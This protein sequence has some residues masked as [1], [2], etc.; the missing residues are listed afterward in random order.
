MSASCHFDFSELQTMARTL[1]G[2]GLFKADNPDQTLALMLLAQAEGRHPA[3]VVRDYNII[4]GRPAKK[5]EA[6]LRDFLAAGGRVEWR[7]LTDQ[8]CSA[9][10]SHPAGGTAQINWT[11]T[12]ARTA[13]LTHPMW[14]KYPRQMLRSRVVSEGVRT[15]YPLA[16]SGLYVEEEVCEFH[17]DAPWLEPHAL[18]GDPD[19]RAE[20]TLP[21]EPEIGEPLQWEP[22][23]QAARRSARQLKIDGD[24]QR[25][26]A[27]IEEC[28]LEELSRWEEEFDE[29]TAHLP[30]SWLDPVR[31]W[32]ALRREEIYFDAACAEMDEDYAARV[33][34]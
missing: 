29:R 28:S 31:D 16:T 13:G 32:I 14:T 21:L 5:S 19:G 3:S 12:R 18:D 33:C 27:A 15:V 7:R 20:P 9:S 23:P 1:S 4:D 22:A 25:I 10:F 30:R 8:V 11:M 2:S 26:R 34:A 6:M 24:D 17:A